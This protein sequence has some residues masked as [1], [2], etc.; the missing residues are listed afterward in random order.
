M[1]LDGLV[2]RTL[3]A[4]RALRINGDLWGPLMGRLA[5]RENGLLLNN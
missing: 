2:G 3:I 4:Y 5:T 1:I